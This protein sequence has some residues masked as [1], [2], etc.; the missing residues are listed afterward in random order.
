[1]K[2]SQ[3]C[4]ILFLEYDKE[5]FSCRRAQHAS[6]LG[7]VSY[8]AV[9]VRYVF[10]VRVSYICEINVYP[11]LRYAR[12]LSEFISLSLSFFSFFCAFVSVLFPMLSRLSSIHG[13]VCSS[14]VNQCITHD[15]SVIKIKI[16]K[17]PYANK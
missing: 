4:T 5:R 3:A 15:F 10:S 11:T 8:I 1:M 9:R 6:S 13:L 7:N 14:K 16:L 12:Y 17:N 2:S